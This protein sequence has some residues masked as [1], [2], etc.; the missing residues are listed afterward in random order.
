VIVLVEIAIY[1]YINNLYGL[2]EYTRFEYFFLKF[3]PR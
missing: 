2:N 1:Q 3:N